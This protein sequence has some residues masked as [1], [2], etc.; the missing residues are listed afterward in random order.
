MLATADAKAHILTRPDPAAPILKTLSGTEIS[1]RAGTVIAAGERKHTFA[2]DT[3]IAIV[4]LDA[5]RDY[6]IGVGDDGAPYAT[7]CDTNPLASGWIAGFH[8]APG[9]NAEA[10]A[11]GDGVPAINPRSLWDVGFR[12]AC[13]DP[14]GM[15]RVDCGGRSLWV[16]IY[17]LGTGH[18]DQCT[19]RHGVEIADGRSLA[20]LDYTTAVEIYAGHGKRLL[21]C[22]EF[23]AAAYGVKERSSADHDPKSTGLD[24]AR[25]SRFG[26]MQATGNLW[27]WGTDG[28]PDDPRPSIFGGCWFSGSYAGSRCAHLGFHPGSSSDIIS[29][30]G[31]CD[32]LNPA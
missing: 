31:A 11:G 20:K 13:A 10:C 28:H 24:A 27:I 22:E 21:T 2:A 4:S 6:A 15:T 32:H 3:P 26:L 17:L 16:D 7:A 25:T 19:S 1:I 5:G 18:R 12:P 9:G 29:A 8:F 30:R 14:R 23:F